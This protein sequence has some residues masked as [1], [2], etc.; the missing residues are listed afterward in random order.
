VN[1]SG[2]VRQVGEPNLVTTYGEQAQHVDQMYPVYWRKQRHRFEWR[3]LI[4]ATY[5]LGW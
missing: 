2:I 3:V 1:E 4:Y 5:A